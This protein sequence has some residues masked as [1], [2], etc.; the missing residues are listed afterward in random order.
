MQTRCGALLAMVCFAV[1]SVAGADTKVVDPAEYGFSPD[2]TPDVNRKALQRALDGGRRTVRSTIS[3]VYGLDQT[4]FI[5]SDTVLEFAPGTVLKK[6]KPYCNVLVNRGAFSYG[7]D[8]N[9]VVRNVEISV[10]GMTSKS[11]VP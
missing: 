1:A 8:S 6:M 11:D 4:V 3:G 10:N 7:C 5:D 9:I 2:A